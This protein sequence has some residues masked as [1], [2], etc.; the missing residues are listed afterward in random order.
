MFLLPFVVKL[1]IVKILYR[2]M[3]PDSTVH[4]VDIFQSLRQLV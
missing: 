2:S 4:A 3:L 1:K